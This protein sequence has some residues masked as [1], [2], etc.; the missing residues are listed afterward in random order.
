MSY[1]KKP[2]RRDLLMDWLFARKGCLILTVGV[3]ALLLVTVF[4][5]VPA[6]FMGEPPCILEE[7]PCVP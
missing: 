6:F 1:K 5:L 7:P 3:T 4:F 2:R